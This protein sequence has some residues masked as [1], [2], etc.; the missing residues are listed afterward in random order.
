MHQLVNVMHGRLPGSD[1]DTAHA[2]ILA[3][4]QD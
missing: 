1:V 2:N 3:R 4:W